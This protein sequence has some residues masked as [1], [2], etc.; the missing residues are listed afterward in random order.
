M[1]TACVLVPQNA[2]PVNRSLFHMLHPQGRQLITGWARRGA[3]VPHHADAS[4]YFEG[5]IYV[6][7][8][9]NGWGSCVTGTD[10]DRDWVDA[11]AAD[12]ELART[13]LDSLRDDASSADFLS[14]FADL[15]PIF[16]SSEIRRRGIRVPAN[17]ARHQRIDTYLQ[18]EISFEPSCWRQHRDQQ[19]PRD[20]FHTFKV[21]YRVRCNLFHGE[22]TL[23]SENDRQIVSSAY[24]V[25]LH[26]AR[27]LELLP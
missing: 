6:W 2:R 3:G 10:L 4:A 8:A 20:W 22:K 19:V 14:R 18:H 15:W 13:F 24:P 27:V 9:L 12:P 21:L 23:D 11:V 7:F 25:L 1:A 26:I 5:F 16:K 17:C